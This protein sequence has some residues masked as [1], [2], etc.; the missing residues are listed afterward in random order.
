MDT[1]QTH[2]ALAKAFHEIT[3]SL[4]G[5]FNTYD[6]D[7]SIAEAAAETLGRIYHSHLLRNS[8][9]SGTFDPRGPLRGL[10]DEMES[11]ADWAA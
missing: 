11:A 9:E 4:I 1:Q 2:I 3:V 8:N 6:L 5:I 10:A 7:P